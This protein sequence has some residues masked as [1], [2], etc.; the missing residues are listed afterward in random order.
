MPILK[1]AVIGASGFVGR[2][3]WASYR[4]CYPDCVGTSFSQT[5]PGLT[6]FDIRSPDLKRLRLEETGHQAVVIA[7]A[8]PNVSYC[9]QEREASH[10]VNVSGT[11]ELIRQLGRT[12][13]AVMF[14]SSDYAFEG[15]TGRYRDDAETR[16][17]TEYGRQK[18]LVEREIP[19][20]TQKYAIVRLS[21]IYGL[22]KNDGTLLDEIARSLATGMEVRAAADQCFCPTEVSDLVAAI[23]AIQQTES[24]R[25]MNICSDEIWSRFEI[26][27]AIA[28]AMG[29]VRCRVQKIS[30]HDLPSMKGRPLNT[31]MVCS[32]KS[33]EARMLFRPLR[34]AIAVA[35]ANWSVGRRGG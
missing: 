9:E 3:L 6:P 27:C 21:K 28:D 19:S 22:E 17:T 24:N 16:P 15:S 11:L 12:S 8:K 30:L 13:L 20:L 10:A 35:A 23:H 25:I 5:G 1:T 2:H 7:S 14:I 33:D 26:A 31:S 29:L 34:D 18:V 32:R 4:Q